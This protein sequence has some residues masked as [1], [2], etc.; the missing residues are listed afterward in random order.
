MT[1]ISEP[2]RHRMNDAGSARTPSSHIIN[3]RHTDRQENGGSF[4]RTDDG[5]QFMSLSQE[6]P[7]IRTE[8]CSGLRAAVE[9]ESQTTDSVKEVA[10][11]CARQVLLSTT[12]LQSRTW[13][14]SSTLFLTQ[15]SKRYKT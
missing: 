12:R 7:I 15:Q 10:G 14:S 1:A 8:L 4:P 6:L 2:V 3:K 9:T 5:G 13:I 11:G